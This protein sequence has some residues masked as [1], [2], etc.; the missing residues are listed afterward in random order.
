T[1]SIEELWTVLGQKQLVGR[2][3]ILTTF[4]ELQRD[5][6]GRLDA[7]NEHRGQLDLWI[8]EHPRQLARQNALWKLIIPWLFD[9]ADDHRLDPQRAAGVASRAVAVINQEPGDARTHGPHADQSD[10]GDLHRSSL[11]H[12]RLRRLEMFDSGWFRLASCYLDA[13]R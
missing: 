4:E 7:A 13:A 9:V 2:N 5:G 12:I 3:D 11:W 6:P 8:F 10:L 1:G